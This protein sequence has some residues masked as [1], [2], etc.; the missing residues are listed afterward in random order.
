MTRAARPKA[1]TSEE[2]YEIQLAVRGR[3]AK[4]SA[5]VRPPNF[6]ELCAAMA[7]TEGEEQK[8]QL[9]ETCA[10]DFDPTLPITAKRA[11]GH[12]I[13]ELSGNDL[14][15]FEITEHD[16][17]PEAAQAVEDRRE[18]KPD[19]VF[20]CLSMD[21]R[22]YVFLQPHENVIDSAA[23]KKKNSNAGI[24]IDLGVVEAHCLFGDID[25]LKREK[26]AAI[27]ELFKKLA[28]I[29]GAA[30]TAVVKKV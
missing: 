21:D 28:E 8:L 3:M 17:S 19:A 7:F 16:L 5:L 1:P 9:F 27:S 15:A 25:Y 12:H 22:E 29:N 14:T 26:P 10:V 24:K 23:T 20:V 4:L 11:L 18:K 30:A 13:M 6:D 2:R